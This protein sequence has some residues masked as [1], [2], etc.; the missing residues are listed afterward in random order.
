MGNKG[1]SKYKISV[2]DLKSV[3]LDPLGSV[4]FFFFFF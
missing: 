1:K 2:S 3:I 4:F